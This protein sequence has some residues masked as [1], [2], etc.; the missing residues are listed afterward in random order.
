[1][2]TPV[3]E[4]YGKEYD[5]NPK[6]ADWYW[7]LGII[8]VALAIAS[9]LFVDYLL[10]LLIVIAGVALS[11]HAARHP[12]THR[13]ALTTEGLLIDNDLHPYSSMHSFSMLEYVKGG[14]PPLLSIKTH[15]WFSPHLLISLN[16]VD[17]D[18]LYTYL[19][20]RIEEGEH[21]HTLSDLVAA[22][23]GF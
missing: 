18:A 14:R 12:P 7:A 9:L 6:S 16:D 15:S 11:L 13:F 10:A 20:D 21:K 2:Q 4:W 22:W 23:L 8:T 3:F 17:A 19:L 5:P 1:M